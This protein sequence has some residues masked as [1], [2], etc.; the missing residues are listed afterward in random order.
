[1]KVIFVIVSMAG[2]GAER[3]ISI[4]ANQF[5]K[6]GIDVCIMMTAGAHTALQ[7]GGN[8]WRQSEKKNRKN[9]EYAHRL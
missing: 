3:V 4:L 6:S 2:G 5:V 8:K 7:Y 1:M 9:P